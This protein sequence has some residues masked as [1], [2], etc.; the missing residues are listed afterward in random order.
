MS[1]QG[2]DQ[3]LRQAARRLGLLHGKTRE[4]A[5][6]H[7]PRIVPDLVLCS[8]PMGPRWRREE[9][10]YIGV[11][12][13]VVCA[14]ARQTAGTLIVGPQHLSVVDGRLIRGGDYG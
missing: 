5:Y 6:C 11:Y 10:G 4:C 1:Q 14:R 8:F 7:T 2:Y 13:C 12:A 3:T 9:D